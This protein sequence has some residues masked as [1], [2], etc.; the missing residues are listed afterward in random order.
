[1]NAS[2]PW[3]ANTRCTALPEN[4]IRSANMNTF[5]GTPASRIQ[6]SPKSTSALRPDGESAR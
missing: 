2:W 6:N 1:M 4:D 3:D 5:V